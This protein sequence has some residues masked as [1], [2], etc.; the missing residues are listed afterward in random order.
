MPSTTAKEHNPK[1][2]QL[3]STGM[4]ANVVFVNIDWKA[5][6]H[7]KTLKVNM[8]ILD[9]TI[10]GMVQKMNPTMICMCEVGAATFPLTEEQMQQVSYQ[11]MQAWKETATEHFELQSMFEVGAP[12]MTI[13][14]DGAIQCSHH[15]ILKDV[16]NAK[17]LP[18]TA[19]TFLCSGSGHN[20]FDSINVHAPSPGKKRKQQHRTQP[21]AGMLTDQQR[22]T[23]LTNLLQRDSKS[24][25][26]LTI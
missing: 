7:G 2:P 10:A 25:P 12:Y 4:S 11:C 1:V 19:Q 16:Y 17:G 9:K 20:M 5:I 13:Y 24:M 21:Q 18:R 22:M 23:L 6:R 26:G 15:R 14:K 3:Q 8:K